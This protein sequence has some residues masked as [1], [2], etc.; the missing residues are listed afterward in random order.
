MSN[1]AIEHLK[2]ELGDQEVKLEAVAADTSEA[3][4][5]GKQA[6]ARLDAQQ[7]HVD[8]LRAAIAVLKLHDAPKEVNA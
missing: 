6:Q 4:Q 2:S 3:I 7:R 5:L 8:E 1:A